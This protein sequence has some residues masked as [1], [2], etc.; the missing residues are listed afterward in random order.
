LLHNKKYFTKKIYIKLCKLLY[1]N[2]LNKEIN[3][4]VNSKTFDL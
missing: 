2:N 1:D 3:N 4:I